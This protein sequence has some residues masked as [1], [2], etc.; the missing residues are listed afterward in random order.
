VCTA[1][2]TNFFDPATVQILTGGPGGYVVVGTGYIYDAEFDLKR[3]KLFFGAP[4]LEDGL[5][6]L[7]ITTDGGESGVLEDVLEAR[8]FS[9]EYKTV[10][11]RGKYAGV[12]KTGSRVLRE[13]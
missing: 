6:H 3:N 12:W 9:E 11:V 7:R 2:G 13:G 4:A 5:Y 1:L 10:S 8:L